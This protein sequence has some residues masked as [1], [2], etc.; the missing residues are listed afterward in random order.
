M[1]HHIRFVYEEDETVNNL[2]AIWMNDFD[3]STA[4]ATLENVKTWYEELMLQ[5][6]EERAAVL[7][8]W[9]TDASSCALT[10]GAGAKC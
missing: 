4:D 5:N 9:V 2:V 1:G 3:N 10:E 8:Q 6:L 7:L